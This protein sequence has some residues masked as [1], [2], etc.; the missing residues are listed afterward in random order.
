ML[1]YGTSIVSSE[2]LLGVWGTGET[3]H[4][5]QGNRGTKAKF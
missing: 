4:L 2:A 3:G 1:I 5:F